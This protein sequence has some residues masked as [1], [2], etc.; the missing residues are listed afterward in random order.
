MSAVVGKLA[1]RKLKNVDNY[2]KYVIFGFVR[3]LVN[4]DKNIPILINYVILLYSPLIVEKFLV[5]GNFTNYFHLR[6][7]IIKFKKDGWENTSFGSIT[8]PST[9]SYVCKWCIHINRGNDLMI[10]ITSFNEN[11]KK[12]KNKKYLQPGESLWDQNGASYCF[13][14]QNCKYQLNKNG[15]EIW[16]EYGKS[17]GEN[18]I[19]CIELHLGKKQVL[20]SKNK[21]RFGIAYRNIKVGDDIKYKLGISMFGV[22][23]SVTIKS[24]EIC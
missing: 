2:N 23:S 5:I 21:Q 14:S 13:W 15:E 4:L 3:R 18:D 20:F 8:I 11:E 1:L 19:I 17:F 12:M 10:G 7:S 6:R 24:F 9:Q 16:P 22:G